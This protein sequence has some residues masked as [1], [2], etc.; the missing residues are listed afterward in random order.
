MDLCGTFQEKVPPF[1]TACEPEVIE[2][3]GPAVMCPQ[4]KRAYLRMQL[5]Q[6]EKGEDREM[7]P[8]LAPWTKH[9]PL[10]GHV[11]DGTQ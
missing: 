1:S 7:A 5:K 6:R 10:S 11:G 9:S 2:A 4:E 3:G 8:L